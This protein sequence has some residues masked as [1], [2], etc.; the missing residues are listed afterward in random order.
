MRPMKPDKEISV[1]T[2]RIPTAS[3]SIPALVL[4]PKTGAENAVGVL[5][6]HG[7]GY[8][9]GM[10]EMVH[11]SRAVD[12][13]KKFGAVVVSPR[14]SAGGSAPLSCRGRGLLFGADLYEESRPGAGHPAGSDHGRRGKRGLCAAVCLT[15]RDRASVNI[16]FQMPLYPMLDDRDTESSRDN[17][18]QVWNTRKNHIAWKLYL[19]GTPKGHV[20]AYAAPARAQDVSGLPPAYTFVGDGE[21]FFVETLHY[22]EALKSAGIPA[23]VDVYHTDIHA[24]DMMRPELE[25]SKAAAEKFNRAFAY[26]REHY[27]AENA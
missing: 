26:A 23:D 10:K 15:A 3:G 6:I 11:A 27:F 14:L 1:S 25:I 18:G 17:H 9:A 2:I 5:W 22:I 21:P 4:A 12:L 7:G 19:R 16:A 20:P 8:I 24:F 13:V